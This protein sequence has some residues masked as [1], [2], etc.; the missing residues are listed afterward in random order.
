MNIKPAKKINGVLSI[1]GDKSISHRGVIFGSIA[2]GVTEIEGFLMGEDCLSTIQCFRQMG[3]P[4]EIQD[5]KIYIQGKGL[6]GLSAP[7]E[8][9]DVGNSGTTI[10][11]LTGLLAAQSFSTTITGD[12]S[13][14]KRP[15]KRIVEPLRRMGADISGKED[16]NYAPLH[17]QGKELKGIH[18]DLP[19]ASAQVK[20]AI[21][22]GSLYAEGQTT[23][24]EPARSR[25][26][27]ELM[28]NYFGGKIKT[29]GLTI[30]SEPIQQ[31]I[32]KKV[33][34]PGDISSAAFFL[35]AGAILPQ[36][37]LRLTHVGIN[38][39]RN[40]VIQV[41]QKMGANIEILNPR[42][43]SG[44]PVADLVIGSSS[45]QGTIIEGDII[46][47]LID[48]LPILAV[49]ACFAEGIT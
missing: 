38:P 43:V 4:I 6:Q 46:P 40:G 49:A 2:E 22:L 16:G 9:L 33:S 34:I 13:I 29:E 30:T 12:G 39:T 47:T 23:I 11:L 44:E 37:E 1:P 7:K 15:M 26:H 27:T 48:E 42:H 10:R 25:D 20:S 28:M 5:D 35:V 24:V 3:I 18:Y 32:G 19:V 36:S 31:L 8:P 14:Q 45:L 21:L 41:L 17:I